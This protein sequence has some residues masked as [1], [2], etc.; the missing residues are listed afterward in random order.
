VAAAVGLKVAKHGNRSVSSRSGSSD[1]LAAFGINLDMSAESSRQA[2]DDLGVCFLFAPKY[3]TG[4]R[5]AMPVRQQLKT[6]TLFNVLGPLINPAHPPLALIGVY[7]AELVL[8][9]AETL[10]V[11]GYKR[12]AVVHSGGM[13]EVSL[14]APTQ[15]AE[16]NNGDIKSYQLTAEDFGLPA[17]HQD[18]LA[19][20]TPE[21]NRDI[22]TRLLQG[23]GEIAH[24]SAVA[25]NVAMLMRLHGQ[26]DLKANA[27]RVVEVLRS[28]AAY[29]RVTA[30]AARG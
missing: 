6:R 30:L 25:A 19:G 9:I 18:Q 27:Q 7:S 22:L 23:K 5:H 20:G 14:H 4:F 2:L 8:P 15:V 26:E 13:D 16:L 24:E 17:Y 21:E 3:H 29:D 10:R 1:L 12:A 11:L 28:G